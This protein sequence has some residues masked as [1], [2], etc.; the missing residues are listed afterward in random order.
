MQIVTDL[1]SP[2]QL[3]NT[4]NFLIAA[5]GALANDVNA[6]KSVDTKHDTQIRAAAEADH[7]RHA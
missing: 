5:A 1:G 7:P 2:K 6:L 3:A 4:V